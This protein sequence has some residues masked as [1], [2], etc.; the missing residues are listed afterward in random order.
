MSLTTTTIKEMEDSGISNTSEVLRLSS[1]AAPSSP[2]TSNEPVVK[3]PHGGESNMQDS[4]IC[5]GELLNRLS[6]GGDDLKRVTSLESVREFYEPDEDG[7]V[8]L[9]LVVVAGWFLLSNF[10]QIC[11]IF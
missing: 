3:M 11:T 7:D 10:M 5:C 9:H 8:Q 4:G 6:L 1:S 2:M